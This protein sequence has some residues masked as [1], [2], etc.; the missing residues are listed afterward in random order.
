MVPFFYSQQ[1]LFVREGGPV[2]NMDPPA[3][4]ADDPEVISEA[5]NVIVKQSGDP[6]GHLI[7]LK[8]F[9]SRR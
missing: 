4:S 8:Y 3:T 6:T 9:S 5:A 2:S 7:Y 1:G